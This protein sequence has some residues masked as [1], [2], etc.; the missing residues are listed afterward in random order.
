[1]PQASPGC[2]SS[3]GSPRGSSPVGVFRYL[4]LGPLS[5]SPLSAGLELYPLCARACGCVAPRPAALQGQRH[6]P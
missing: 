2:W 6:V 3:E 4:P 5:S 1:M